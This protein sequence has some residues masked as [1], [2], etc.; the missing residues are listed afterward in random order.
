MDVSFQLV[1]SIF[2]AGL[3]ATYLVGRYLYR[4]KRTS[5]CS[6]CAANRTR[7]TMIGTRRGPSGS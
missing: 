3:A 6:S 1:A 7:K 2:L 4:R 5:A